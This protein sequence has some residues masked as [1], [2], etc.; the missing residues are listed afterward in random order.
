MVSLPTRTAQGEGDRCVATG[1]VDSAVPCEPGSA[2]GSVPDWLLRPEDYA[3]LRDRERF[4]QR[5]MLR[6]T[7]LLSHMKLQRGGLEDRAALSP[8]DRALVS[9]DSALRLLG[10]IVTIVCISVASNMFF[11][12]TVLALFLTASALR[13][14]EELIDRLQ[15]PLAAAA[16][17]ALIMLPAVFLGQPA[18]LVRVSLKVFLSVGLVIGLSRS[19][20]YNQLIAGLRFYHVPGL[21]VFVLDITL[22]YIVMLGEVAEGVLMAL[23]LRSVGRNDDKR[24]SSSGVMG[25]TFLKAHDYAGE[26]YE[27]MECRGFTGDYVVPDHRVLSLSAVVYLFMLASEVLYLLLMEGML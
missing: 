7:S 27:A 12:Y 23:R 10:L 3:P 1:S 18:S 20:A 26:M 16:L 2:A 17:T 24:G 11:V 8:V 9:V 14:G 15:L 13:S 5:N 4:L 6:L 19:V 22:K 25:I 21:V